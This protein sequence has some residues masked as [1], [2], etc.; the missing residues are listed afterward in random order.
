MYM[1]LLKKIPF[2]FIILL[3]VLLRC[4]YGGDYQVFRTKDVTVLFEQPLKLA[5]KEVASLYPEIKKNLE[6]ILGWKL[7]LIP[8]VLLIKNRER[9]L[10]MADNP[11]TVAFAVPERNLI[12]IDYSMMITRPFR[13]ETTLKHELCHLLLHHHI[14]ENIL[15][16]W[17][18][19]GVCQWISGGI[20]EIIM[21]QKRSLLIKTALR[22]K[23]ISFRDLQFRFPHEKE[24]RLLAYEESKSF[25]TYI[26]NQ[27]GK[28]GIITIL[29]HMKEGDET[30]AAI[31]K[32]LSIPLENLEQEWH[33]FLRQKTTL[34]TY[35]S[36]N[37]YEILFTFMAFIAIYAFIRLKIKKRDYIDDDDLIVK[38]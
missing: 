33:H 15:P 21:D 25:V 31:L 7:N 14:K 2:S 38:G 10:K 37:L 12:V 27:F 8:S 6:T 23:F 24:P 36:Y 16:R 4:A 32:A 29:K 11:I 26:V 34:F 22:R 20:D 17:F 18:D 35:L 3:A 19:E 13:L 28:A 5:A 1:Q 30:Q 9:F